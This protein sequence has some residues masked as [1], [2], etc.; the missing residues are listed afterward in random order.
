MGWHVE[1]NTVLRLGKDDVD[2]KNLQIGDVFRV[3]R[4]NVRIYIIDIPILLLTEDWKVVGYCAVRESKIKGKSMM[5]VVELI[6][7]FTEKE[8]NVHTNCFEQALK[9]TG[10]LR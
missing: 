2:V 10:Y 6:S 1:V 8:S 7:Q 3:K 5:L 4:Q 9:I